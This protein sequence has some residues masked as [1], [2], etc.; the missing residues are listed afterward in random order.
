MKLNDEEFHRLSQLVEQA[1]DLTEEERGAWLE[2]TS[3]GDRELERMLRFGMAAM[4]TTFLAPVS[5]E[6]RAEALDNVRQENAAVELEAK[7]GDRVGPY[8]LTRLI[9]SG[10][11]GT[12]WLSER[13]DG[14][15]NRTVALKLPKSG[16]GRRHVE[17]MHKERDILAAL[18]HPNIARLYDAGVTDSGHP[19]LA[20]EYVDGSRLDT[21]IHDKNLSIPQRLALFLEVARTV[22]FAHRRL[23]VHRDLKP[24][25][26]LVDTEGRVRLLDFGIA[27]LL[28][29]APSPGAITSPAQRAFTPE[30]ASWEQLSGRR[31][32]VASD[33]YSLGVVLFELLVGQRPYTLQQITAFVLDP[34]RAAEE[35]PLASSKTSDKKLARALRGD[36][37]TIIAKTTR[38]DPDQRYPTVEALADDL[39]RHLRGEP[40]RA[41]PDTR[42]YRFHRFV[43]RNRASVLAASLV[44]TAILGGAGA[45]LWQARVARREARRAEVVKSFIASIFTQA[46]PRE[47]VG[48]AVTAADLLNAA[49]A[50]LNDELSAEPLA[51]AELGVLIGDSFSSLGEPSKGA[52][53]LSA[54]LPHA[55]RELGPRHPLTLHARV[56][57]A[58]SRNMSQDVEGAEHLLSALIPDL[59]AALPDTARDCVKALRSLSFV[60]AKRDRADAAYTSLKQAIDVGERYL[61]REDDDTILAVGLLANTYGRFAQRAEQLEKAKDAVARATSAW[62]N[63]R[64][65]ISLTAAERWYA[66][67]LI[68][69]D[70]PVEAAALLV[71][72]VRDQRAL[73]VVQTVRVWNANL[74][75][76]QALAWSGRLE[77]AIPLMRELVEQEARENANPGDNRRSVLNQLGRMLN[78]ARFGR[79]ALELQL[80]AQEI[81]RTLSASKRW[82]ARLLSDRAWTHASLNQPEEA[83][84]A[85]ATLAALAEVSPVQE[86]DALAARAYNARLQNRVEA[87]LSFAR[88]ALSRVPDVAGVLR[89]RARAQTEVGLALLEGG[90]LQEAEVSLKAAWADFE[91][92]QI[93]PSM[94]SSDCA[95]GLARIDVSAGRHHEAEL[96]LAPIVE[97]WSKIN[98]D[99]PFF[100]EVLYWLARAEAADGRRE[101]SKSTAARARVL[102]ER[103]S[104][105]LLARLVER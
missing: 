45:A 37:D 38:W 85:L 29:D 26:I 51:L 90:H 24:A 14:I 56:M 40:V 23:V 74:T 5:P 36:L 84:A 91:R 35:A 63:R 39:E 13:A 62:G 9:G 47:G 70:R 87:A 98:A 83:E 59:L 6:R 50:R 25:N 64:P 82:E 57:L 69:N 72:V 92:A 88:Q 19:F 46:Q 79:E 49:T 102:L 18:E 103:S 95:L 1:L 65:H 80:R 8:Q 32:T 10:G 21:Y 12:V 2:R 78:A 97:S 67:A 48:G 100:G 44:L 20:M 93:S 89:V 41:R 4:K 42:L 7:A 105:P 104:V 16:L 61:G 11:M 58:E 73:D 31:I 71:N 86:A 101:Q 15:L 77:D 60:Q 43:R 54:A 55:E 53:A 17:E 96:R 22:A 94:L 30:Y 75:L 66:E 99:S 27:K 76:A 81:S 33:V 68:A 52:P 28:E 3:G 34:S